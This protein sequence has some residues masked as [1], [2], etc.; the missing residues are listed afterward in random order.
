[1]K[2][3]ISVLAV[4][5]F[6][7]SIANAELLKNFKYDG[8]LEINS[9]TDSNDFDKDTNKK[10]S[11]TQTRLELNA[12]FDLTQDVSANVSVIKN[13]RDYGAGSEDANTITTKL[14][15]EQAYLNL[16]GVIGIDHKLGRQYYGNAGDMVIYYGPKMWPYNYDKTATPPVGL[17]VNA[18]DG[19]T[20]WWKYDKWNLDVHAIIARDTDNK[21]GGVAP[22]K[23]IDIYGINAKTKIDRFNL[24]AYAYEKIDKTNGVN[25]FI[26]IDVIGAR[27]NWECKFVKGLNLGLEYDMN[28]GNDKN[29]AEEFKGYAYKANVDY[30]MDLMGK[31]G[32]DAEYV[33]NSGDDKPG[34][35]KNEE[36]QAINDDYRPGIIL[37][38]GFSALTSVG[39]GSKTYNIGVNWT[40]EKLNKLNL[41]AKYYDFSA[42]EKSGLTK[43]HLGT[44]TDIVA[45]WTHS[46]NVSV[47]GYYAMFAPEKKNNVT[48]HDAQTM[49]GAAF[50]VKF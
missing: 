3:V 14:F 47:K 27:V 24:N 46:D 18:I 5:A 37:G 36:W 32:F 6:I 4:L 42:A 39:S 12:N 11:Q 45:T 20:G 48:N 43:V 31:L 21:L 13:N 35:T 26:F 9:W 50:V 40:P 33:F 38:G 41:A 44:E 15:F 22:D 19:W 28:M 2:K 49:L 34:D 7:G 8:K 30:T 17:T 16:K 1:M 23:D 25:K 10:M 29:A